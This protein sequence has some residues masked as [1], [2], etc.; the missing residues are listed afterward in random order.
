LPSTK[1]VQ[2][3]RTKCWKLKEETAKTFK[4]RVLKE[5]SWHEGGDA[6]SM[7]MK[8]T[9]CIRKVA[10][11]EFGDVLETSDRWQLQRNLAI[12]RRVEVNE[13]SGDVQHSSMHLHLVHTKNDIDSL[14]FQ[15]DKSGRKYSPG[16]I[17]WDFTGY[18]ISNHSASGGA[19]RIRHLGSTKS[20]PDLLSTG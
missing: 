17:K 13:T 18:L 3:P 15:D 2:A 5:G 6:N 16:K 11:K 14:T 4:E 1:H 12:D 8:M 20:K 9:T 7:W 10:L 19:D